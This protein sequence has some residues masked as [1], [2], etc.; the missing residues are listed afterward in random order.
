MKL[1]CTLFLF[2]VLLTAGC[3]GAD[4]GA[5]D[6][7]QT[8][9]E[10][11]DDLRTI[12]L[13]MG[14][15]PDPQYAPFYVAVEK[16]Y[17]AEEGLEI[18][19]DYSFETDGV[20]LVG[21]NERPFAIVSGEQVVLARAQELP[22]VY[23][24]E[25]FQEFPIAVVSRDEAGIETPSDLAGKT[26]GLPGFFGATYA[27]YAG[28]LSAAGLPL[29]AVNAEEIGFTQVEALLA[30]QVDAVVGYVNNE[31][32]QLLEQGVDVDVLYVADYVDLVANGIITNE[33]VIADE[34]EL[35][36]HFVR[37]T[38]RGLAD[39]LADPEEAYE[40]SKLYVEGLDD[41]RMNVLA[42]SLPLWE[43]ETLGVTDPASWEQTEAVLLEMRLLDAPVEEL[44]AAYTNRFVLENQPE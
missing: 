27:G 9:V 2:L 12:E 8:T 7:V 23:V 43:A 5:V 21:A 33:T 22:V 35:V 28:L 38:L 20:A 30:G 10:Q 11:E 24:L 40:I 19:F 15:I 34:P 6:A 3:A 26:V 37:A 29:E 1:L 31:P 25:W 18:A 17:Y 44:E 4:P 36:G 16:G 39:T 14:F 42:A 13:P 41:S 32:V